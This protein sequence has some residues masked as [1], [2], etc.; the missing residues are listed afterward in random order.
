M[1]KMIEA[2]PKTAAM[3]VYEEAHC[4]F[5]EPHA[6]LLICKSN[7]CK[8]Q[9]YSNTNVIDYQ[10]YERIAKTKSGERA[11]IHYDGS[12]QHSFKYTPKAWETIYCRREPTPV[13]C[14]YLGVC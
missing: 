3:L 2:H 13:E 14:E 4:G 11:L 12:T 8:E 6:F 9:W 7:T 10:I 1:F 5:Q